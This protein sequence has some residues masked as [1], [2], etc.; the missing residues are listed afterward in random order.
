MCGGGGGER[1]CHSVC[2]YMLCVPTEL[3]SLIEEAL[4]EERLQ[5]Q[6]SIP[7][8]IEPRPSTVLARE[9]EEDSKR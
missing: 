7:Q 2:F 6:P 8:L 5:L 4:Q 3:R 1:W 9:R